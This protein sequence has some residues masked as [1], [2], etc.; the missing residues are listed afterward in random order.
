VTLSKQVK[1]LYGKNFKSL[2]K[3]IKEGL[4][5]SKDLTCSWIG[6]INRI[7]MAILL[8][9]I[10]RFNAILVKIPIQFVTEFDSKLQTHLEEQNPRITKTIL[11]NKRTSGGITIPDCKLYY[12][13][14]MI[15]TAGYL[16]SE[17]QVKQ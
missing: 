6:R 3:E 10:Y 15:K 13:A 11:N 5:R 12:R 16:Y 2:N 14:I 4:R 8:K 17:K 9:A 7:K 1:F